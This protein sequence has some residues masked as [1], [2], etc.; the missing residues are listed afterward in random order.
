M[1]N[2]MSDEGREEAERNFSERIGS[3]PS[4]SV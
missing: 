3:A 4:E 2:L 1:G